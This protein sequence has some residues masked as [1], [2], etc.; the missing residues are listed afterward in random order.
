MTYLT[1]D[2]VKKHLNV[3]SSFTDDDS[4]IELLADV[5]EQKVAKELHVTLQSLSTIVGTSE[6]PTPLKQAMLLNV[7]HYY[8]NREEASTALSR[9]IEQGS[10]WLIDLYRDYS[11]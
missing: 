7:G 9:P 1:L 11:L 4:Y 10:K 6:I 8:A 5:A 3:E 2:I